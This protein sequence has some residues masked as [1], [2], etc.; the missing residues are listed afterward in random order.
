QAA[1]AVA[2][3]IYTFSPTLINELS[4]GVN[5]GKQGVNPLDN[6]TSTATGGTKTYEDNLL[7]LKGGNGKA[8]SLPRINQGS[9]VLNLLPQVRFDLP[10]GFSAQSS[11]QG[12]TGAPAFGH[13]SRWPFTGTD[14]LQ[15]VTDTVTW[16]KGAHNIKGGLYI[17]RMAR[18]VSVYST[19]NIAG[20]Y[21]FG[22][23]RS[24]PFDTGYAYSNAMLGSIFA[25]GDDN[26]KQV[27]HARYTQ[28]EWFGQ[29]TW[30]ASRRLTFDFGVRFHRM[31][32]LYSAGATLGLFRQEE[33]D[34][35]K[36]GQLLF[37]AMVN[38]QKAAI[39]PVT[40]AVFPYV[41][42]GTFDT[43]SYPA[44]GTPFSGI[45][46]YDSHFFHT[47]PIQRGPRLGFAW[48]MFGAGKT[49]MRG[50]FGII[51]GRNWT[52][53]NIG[54]TGAGVG[55]IAAPPNFQSPVVLYT[56]FTNLQGSQTF[57]T[58]QTVVG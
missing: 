50:G 30:K 19:Y 56:N 6:P 51:V 20:T 10:S 35:K 48:D 34:P 47:P 13:D 33:Y 41:R 11:G 5:R 36:V 53:D 38:G 22:T 23:D 8:I 25:Y 9:N 37:P 32:D 52:V 46:Q 55:P 16:V 3:A 24:N 15:T 17:E 27:N 54:A 42:Q 2:T 45:H 28:I 12:I 57:F 31:G 40:G 14:M 7:P 1:G 58:P 44:G 18:N 49:A 21:Y 4:Y 29:D 39:N 43:S 26:K